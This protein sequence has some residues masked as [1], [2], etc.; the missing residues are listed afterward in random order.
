M[1]VLGEVDSDICSVVRVL[2]RLPSSRWMR[3]LV[4]PRAAVLGGSWY[5]LTNGFRV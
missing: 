3:V 2:H 1:Q 4:E 5:F